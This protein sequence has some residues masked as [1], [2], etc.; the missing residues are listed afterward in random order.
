[1]ARLYADEQF[2][3]AVV[4]ALRGHSHDVVTSLEAGHANRGVPDDEVLAFA[5]REARAVLTLNRRDFFRLHARSPA[6]AGIIACTLDIDALGQA[7]RI[8][9]A[10]RDR[11]S[12]MGEL[13]RVNKPAR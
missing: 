7:E 6:H 11:G 10:I 5:T 3:L 12:L 2:P 13:V 9:A 1:M 8:D 4:R